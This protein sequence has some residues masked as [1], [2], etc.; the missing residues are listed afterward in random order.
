MLSQR[1]KKNPEPT[2]AKMAAN[3]DF[4]NL[5]TVFVNFTSRG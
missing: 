4:V 3:E 1:Y 2:R 5:A